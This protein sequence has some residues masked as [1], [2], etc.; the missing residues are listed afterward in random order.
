MNSR[1]FLRQANV[2]L[3]CLLLSLSGCA[4]TDP[5]RFYALTSVGEPLTDQERN[6][7]TS[8]PVIVVGPVKIPEYL[9]WPQIVTHTG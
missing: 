3:I 9:K 4:H 5:S 6:M 2:A 1:Y 8:D 7:V